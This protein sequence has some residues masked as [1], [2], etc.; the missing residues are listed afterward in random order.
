M[1]NREYTQY[2]YNS[3]FPPGPSGPMF[4]PDGAG[5]GTQPGLLNRMGSETGTFVSG[6]Y[7]SGERSYG[8]IKSM[9]SAGAALPTEEVPSGHH[10]GYYA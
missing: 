10:P 4:L 7:V 2:T 1:H 9:L 6:T 5:M 3:Q 8:D